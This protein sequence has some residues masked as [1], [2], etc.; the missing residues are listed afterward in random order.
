MVAKPNKSEDDGQ[1]TG[2]VEGVYVLRVEVSTRYGVEGN[3]GKGQCLVEEEGTR[4]CGVV[5]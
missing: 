5:F 4:A 3:P 2:N 1:G